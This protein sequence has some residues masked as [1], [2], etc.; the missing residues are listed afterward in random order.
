[1]CRFQAL[2]DKEGGQ[3]LSIIID[4]MSRWKTSL[5]HLRRLPKGLDGEWHPLLFPLTASKV[6]NFAVLADFQFGGQLKGEG[7]GSSATCS[8]ILEDLHAVQ[9][10]TGKLPPNLKLQ[11][12]NCAKDNKNSTVL[13][14][15]ALLVQEGVVEDAEVRV[16]SIVALYSIIVHSSIIEL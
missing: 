8:T 15:V 3:V 6:H 5:P 14:L 13:G 1:M 11:M 16:L 4:A 2:C 12:D 9:R 7:S 10:L